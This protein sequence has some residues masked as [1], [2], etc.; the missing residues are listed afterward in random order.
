MVRH[1]AGSRI[2]VTRDSVGAADDIHAPHERTVRLPGAAA[3]EEAIG[4]LLREDYL[5]Q[6]AGGRATWVL[7]SN[8]PLAVVAQQWCEPR[9]VRAVPL[10][11]RALD[12]DGPTLRCHFSYLGQLD[13]EL[14][15]AVL[16]PLRLRAL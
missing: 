15:V 11:A 4:A 2:Y 13:P 10:D 8:I 9:P 6:V 5:S 14:V 12:Y 3:P 1:A 7:A 16:R